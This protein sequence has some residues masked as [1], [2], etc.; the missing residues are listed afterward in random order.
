MRLTAEV[1]VDPV[2][3]LQHEPTFHDASFGAGLDGRVQGTCV[4][5]ADCGKGD[6]QQHS[7]W[8]SQAREESMGCLRQPLQAQ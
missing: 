7:T 1:L 4:F 3:L 2:T 6:H 5:K 8:H